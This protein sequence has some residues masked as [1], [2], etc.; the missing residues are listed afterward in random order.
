MA[1]RPGPAR[2]GVHYMGSLKERI[3]LIVKLLRKDFYDQYRGPQLR[4]LA[5]K[6]VKACPT[7]AEAGEK[8]SGYCEVAAV[9]DWV[10]IN[11]RYSGDTTPIGE[12][13]VDLYQAPWRTVEMGIG[14]CDDIAPLTV[15]LLTYLGYHCWLVVSS[16]PGSDSWDHI[17]CKCSFPRVSPYR[18]LTVDATLGVGKCG[19]EAPHSRYVEFFK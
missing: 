15:A 16:N 4:A 2:L 14:D 12:K 7:R 1:N 17:Y 19:V 8:N 9:H 18:E 5:G 6:I 13:P 3:D 11:V 10:A